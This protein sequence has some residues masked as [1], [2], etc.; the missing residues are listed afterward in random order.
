MITRIKEIKAY[1]DKNVK[2]SEFSGIIQ[3]Y[4]EDILLI[5]N[6]FGYSNRAEKIPINENT[7]F[8][9]A[10]GS[11]GFTS[12][13]VAK[14]IERN[15]INEN[16]RIK[17]VLDSNLPNFNNEITVNHLLTHTSGITSYFEEDVNPDY[18]DL[19][20]NLP[21]YQ[22][23]EPKDFL[24]LF[25]NKKM[26]FTPGKKFEYND[27]GY[28]LLGL[29]VEKV[30]GKKFDEYIVENIFKPSGMTSSGYF[31]SNNLPENTALS[32]IKNKN[33]TFRT[34]I[35]SVPIKGG[36]DGG[37]Y[38][39][40]YDMYRFWK[41]VSNGKLIS[42][43]LFKTFTQPL[44]YDEE[45]KCFYGKGFWIDNKNGKTEKIS[46]EG[47]DPG[48]SF[49][50]SYFPEKKITFTMLSNNSYSLWKLYY[51]IENILIS[52]SL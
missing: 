34:N 2:N 37:A 11:K 5:N 19:W 50:S 21:V 36:P 32:Y 46:L 9:I 51:G 47:F 39:T 18:E 33:G 28:I 15:L 22:M 48:V 42:E 49:K 30:S 6:V 23:K 44:N 27:A 20:K 25:K 26:K 45:E 43:N 4:S 41:N 29:I 10:S 16:T 17:D 14:L 24:P 8:Q 13:A 40:G 31:S 38:T 7:R 1:I 12:I 3:I 52:D 35:F